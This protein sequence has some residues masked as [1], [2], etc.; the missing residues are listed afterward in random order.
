LYACVRLI[1]DS[2]ASLPLK[3]YTTAGS[4]GRGVRYEGPSIFDQPSADGTIYDWIFQ[5]M[6][7]LLLHGNAWGLI[8]GRDGYGFPTGIEWLPPDMVD[9]QDDPQQPWN[10]MRTRVFVFGRQMA[11]WRNELFHVKAFSL[12]GRTEG[13][14]PLRAFALT[15][16]N[17]MEAAR[18]GTDWF[19]AGGFPPGT[20]QNCV[21]TETELLSR[22][23]W[24][25][26]DQV[27]PGTEALTL[28]TETSQSEWQPVKRVYVN[29]GPN[30]V[31]AMRN[32]SHSSVSTPNHRWPAV[33]PGAAEIAWY[34]T[35][36]L[37]L[38][39]QLLISETERTDKVADLAVRQETIDGPVWCPVTENKT[40]FA[41][42]DGTCYFTGNTE[43][44]IDS[45][46]AAEIRESLT[47]AIRNR[48][49]L[50][51]GRDW[52][53]KPVVVP[54]SEAQFIE[55]LQL[56]ATQIAAIYGLPAERVGGLKSSSLT[57][58]ADG[59]TEILTRRGW[60]RYDQVTTADTCLGLDIKTGLSRW[61][62]V[63]AVNVF[64]DGPYDVI[65]LENSTHSSVTTPNHRWPIMLSGVTRTR[66]GWQW[67]TTE[68]LPA[69]ARICAAAPVEAPEPKW[70]DATVEL[71]AWLWT[72]GHI[73]P[74]GGVQLT[75][76]QRVNPGNVARIRAALTEIFG[77]AAEK[78]HVRSRP[79]WRED[80]HDD[81]GIVQFRLNALAGA[82]L[83]QHAPGKVVSTE[84]LASLTRAQLEL[85]YQ[86]SIDADGW[87][88]LNGR[89]SSL[90]Q[91]DRA[92][93]DAFQIACAL[94]GRSGVVR[95]LPTSGQWYMAVQVTSWRKPAGHPEYKSRET[96]P[97][98]WCPTTPSGTWFAR[99]NGTTY[100]TG[101]TNVEMSA[102]QIIEA[103]RPWL[104]RL[105][106]AFFALLPTSRYTRF[107]TDA[108]L[109]TDLASRANIYKI[110]RDVGIRTVDELRE[111][112]DL[113][114]M[115]KG[116]GSEAIPHEIMVQLVRAGVVQGVPTSLL[117]ALTLDTDLLV[118]VLEKLQAQGLAAAAVPG[119]APV[120]ESPQGQVGMS[121]DKLRGFGDIDPVDV[122][123]MV[124]ILQKAARKQRL[125]EQQAS[126]PDYIGPWI[127][128]EEELARLTA[129][130][131]NGNG[132]H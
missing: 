51:Y 83:T 72:E 118:P 127:P 41:R 98:V 116:V 80:Y 111:L 96:V 87:R 59:E 40:W 35:S 1:A 104:V 33:A 8:T 65:R 106:T 86:V 32:L 23:G 115:P 50:V 60:L 94:T 21:D 109:K 17:G 78:L 101:N 120:Q 31:V 121:I 7:S 90:A 97:L 88:R 43:I 47:T 66:E 123:Q 76:S 128:S 103:L 113:E 124:A 16:L 11:D 14:S 26:Y 6:T 92:R 30:E 52:D 56:N 99:R 18:Y 125:R 61:Q 132:R 112:E 57:Y 9:V 122:D 5:C 105:E 55:S 3:I 110:F 71:V 36:T 108:L 107:Y 93:L 46:A 4:T 84:F 77:P 129:A 48:Q 102:L 29:E 20:F 81:R 10:K 22:D 58:C 19:A 28:N 27:K 37:P 89:A 130:N 95:Q 91:K 75:Q 82:V 24:L 44:E 12:P 42:R 25:R 39:A 34:R 63:Q 85:F 64:D 79:S 68:T 73:D 131:G 45:T 74:Y 67:R 2:T 100:F 119:K 53:Y 49:P 15:I 69:D 70:S 54:P 114:P 117:P 13:I 62:R 126:G 38:D